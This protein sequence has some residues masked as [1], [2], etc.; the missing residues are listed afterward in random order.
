ML[1]SLR[2]GPGRDILAHMQRYISLYIQIVFCTDSVWR[3]DLV[4]A[5]YFIFFIYLFIEQLR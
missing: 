1:K 5:Y 4:V 3:P 2:T